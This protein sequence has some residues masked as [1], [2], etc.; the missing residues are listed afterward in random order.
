MEKD[1]SFEEAMKELEQ[2][3]ESLENGNLTLEGALEMFEKGICLTA[4]CNKK[5]DVAEK[6]ITVLLENR[7]GSFQEKDFLAEDNQ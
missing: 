3:V 6:K 4:L 1:I 2:V 7:D 5:L